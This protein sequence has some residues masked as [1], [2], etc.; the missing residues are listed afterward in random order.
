MN[1]DEFL[2]SIKERAIEKHVP[3]LQDKSLEFIS[4]I[5]KLKKTLR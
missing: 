3:I 5:L 4:F 1:L 2:A